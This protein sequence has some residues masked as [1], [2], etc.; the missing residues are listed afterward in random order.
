M[1]TR[2]SNSID[3]SLTKN[4]NLALCFGKAMKGYPAPEPNTLKSVTGK[5]RA[6]S[7]TEE[8]RER[9]KMFPKGALRHPTHEE[10]YD[11]LEARWYRDL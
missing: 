10:S 9:L 3:H 2:A 5:Q 6:M 4:H 1:E 11:G 8:H 7:T